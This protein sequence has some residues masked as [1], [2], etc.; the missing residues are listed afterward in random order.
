[1]PTTTDDDE[2]R[3]V[4]LA[5]VNR[6][7]AEDGLVAVVCGQTLTAIFST[8]IINFVFFCTEFEN[9]QLCPDST[10]SHILRPNSYVLPNQ[11]KMHTGMRLNG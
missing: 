9:V 7:C 3:F 2:R 1:M 4:R 6:V 11:C 5:S 10:D 8:R